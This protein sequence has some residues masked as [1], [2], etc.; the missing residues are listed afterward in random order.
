MK[1]DDSLLKIII[2]FLLSFIISIILAVL[3]VLALFF[4][5]Q[6]LTFRLRENMSVFGER[7]KHTYLCLLL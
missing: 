5:E 2:V 4:I 7:L 6:I 3:L 1:K